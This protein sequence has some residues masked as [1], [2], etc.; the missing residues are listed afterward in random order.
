MD[1][2]VVATVLVLECDTLGVARLVRVGSISF[3]IGTAAE[4]PDR[5]NL[6]RGGEAAEIR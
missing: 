1:R 4:I 3:A 6:K 2:S 5:R